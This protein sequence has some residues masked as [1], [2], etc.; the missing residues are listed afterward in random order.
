[1]AGL[2]PLGPAQESLRAAVQDVGLPSVPNVSP[3]EEAQILLSAGA[4]IEHALLVEYLYASWSLGNDPAG[5]QI[6]AIAIQE[7]CHLI[8]VQNLLL[9][10]GAQPFM[11]RQ[12]QDPNPMLDP[13]PFALRPLDEN[14]LTDFLLAETPPLN[15]MSPDQQNVMRPLIDANKGR[16]HPVGLIYAQ[17]FW[18]FQEN[19][20]PDPLWP[21]VATSGFTPGRHITGAFP[22]QGSDATLQVDPAVEPNWDAGHDRGGVFQKID[23]AVAARQAIADIAKQ[24]EGLASPGDVLS[25]FEIFL[26]IFENKTLLA[27][28]PILKFPTDPSP[29]NV[30]QKLAAALCQVFNIRYQILLTALRGALSRSRAVLADAA[31]RNKYTSWTFEEM[32][33][34]V[35]GLMRSITKLPAVDGGSAA[36]LAAAPPFSQNNFTLPDTQAAIDQLL[37]DLHA[38][39]AKAVNAALALSPD[40]VT[41]LALQSIQKTDKKRFPNP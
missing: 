7:M 14:V 13:F 34:S 10:T 3:L 39:S 26:L 24:G 20:Q 28:L 21:E 9:F 38:S 22:G 30:T 11:D 32:H 12:D 31:V 18:L 23:S 17:L 33:G 25:H 6:F 29:A 5:S 35:Q 16:F 27:Q 19:D 40:I 36:Q 8:T 2:A 15:K 37:A 1:M 4:E 41:K